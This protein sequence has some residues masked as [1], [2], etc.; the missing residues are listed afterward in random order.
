MRCAYCKAPVPC[1]PAHWCD[2]AE[3][4]VGAYEE[5]PATLTL[6]AELVR[7]VEEALR[8]SSV[9][10]HSKGGMVGSYYAN[11]AASCGAALAAL[12]KHTKGGGA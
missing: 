4:W 1:P 10:W 11:L 5:E 8:E 3:C 9:E 7:Q 12:K 6:P 2:V